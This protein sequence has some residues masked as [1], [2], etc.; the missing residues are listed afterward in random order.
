MMQLRPR[1]NHPTTWGLCDL[2]AGHPFDHATTNGQPVGKPAGNPTTLKQ[3]QE[4][5]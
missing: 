2:P 3:N 4:P 5:T 1:C